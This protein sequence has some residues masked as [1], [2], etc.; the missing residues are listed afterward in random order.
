MPPRTISKDLKDRIPILFFDKGLSVAHICSVL[1][2]KKTLVYSTLER[3]TVFGTSCNPNARHSGRP[4][5]LSPLDIKF[6]EALLEQS[7]TIYLDEIQEKLLTQRGVAVSLTTLFRT[8]R[9][10]HFSC[11]CVSVRALERNDLLRSAFM[12]RI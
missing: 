8:L 1:G 10:L 2:V 11:K 9:Q 4:R 6:I 5:F 3:H 12:N 7:H